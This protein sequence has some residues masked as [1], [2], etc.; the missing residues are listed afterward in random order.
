MM[1]LPEAVFLRSRGRPEGNIMDEDELDF[2]DF[3]DEDFEP[4]EKGKVMSDKFYAVLSHTCKRY[5][6]YEDAVAQAK[7]AAANTGYNSGNYYIA[8]TIAMAKQPV[9]EVEVVKLV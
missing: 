5:E 9:P 4:E 3:I 1:D 2:L 6:K 7:R 8:E